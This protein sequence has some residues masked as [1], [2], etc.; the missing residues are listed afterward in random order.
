MDFPLNLSPGELFDFLPPGGERRIVIVNGTY[1]PRVGLHVVDMLPLLP[2]QGARRDAYPI[3]SGLVSDAIEKAMT[4][5][6]D[7]PQ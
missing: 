7:V 1:P 5:V 4:L 2:G 6:A 3:P